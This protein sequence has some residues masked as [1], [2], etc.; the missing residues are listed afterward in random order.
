MGDERVVDRVADQIFFAER[1]IHAAD[2]EVDQLV[3]MPKAGDVL[4]VHIEFSELKR[5]TGIF[6]LGQIKL[7]E[8][9]SVVPERRFDEELCFINPEFGIREDT[10]RSTAKKTSAAFAGKPN[11]PE[12]KTER[13][14]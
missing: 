8:K 12:L 11:S 3:L 2:A 1:N 14:W 7:T 5:V 13:L 10:G 6:A 4:E 9:V